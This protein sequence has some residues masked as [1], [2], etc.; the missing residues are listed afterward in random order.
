MLNQ[1][2]LEFMRYWEQQ[3]EIQSTTKYKILSGLPFASLFGLP[4]IMSILVVYLFVPEW[5]TKVSKMQ[6]GTIPTILIAVSIFV[7]LFAYL[8]MHFKWEQNEE[9]YEKLKAKH[10]QPS[11]AE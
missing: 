5:Y 8:R 6:A 10:N 7:V 4:I 1:K 3:R 9:L 2:Q 11:N